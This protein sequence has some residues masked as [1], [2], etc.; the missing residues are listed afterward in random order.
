METVSAGAA[1]ANEDSMILVERLVTFPREDTPM[2]FLQRD[3]PPD[4]L[5]LVALSLSRG[6]RSEVR[7]WLWIEKLPDNISLLSQRSPV[8]SLGQTHLKVPRSFVHVPP[9]LQGLLD[10]RRYFCETNRNSVVS[11]FGGQVKLCSSPFETSAKPR[12]TLFS[13]ALPTSRVHP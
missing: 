8:H 2:Y 13:H 4:R 7:L 9:L 3:F 1:C 10:T 12:A 11:I 6:G 5:W